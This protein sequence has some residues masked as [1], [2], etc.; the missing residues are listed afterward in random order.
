MKKST[1]KYFYQQ[2]I[3]FNR[4]MYIASGIV[5]V[6]FLFLLLFIEWSA[7]MYFFLFSG[8]FFTLYFSLAS[9]FFSYLIY[10]R[11]ELYKYTWLSSYI[12]NKESVI[13]NVYSGYTEAGH[14]LEN[15]F[16]E[17]K[18]YHLDFYDEKVSITNSIRIAKSIS[19]E[20]DYES[21]RFDTWKV[22]K[23]ASLILFMQ[24]LHELREVDQQVACL[25]EASGCLENEEGKMIVVEHMRDLSN[26]FIYS[27]GAFHFFARK[28]WVKVFDFAGTKVIQEFAIT[29]F[30]RVFV[31]QKQVN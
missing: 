12:S 5:I 25:Q 30:V 31:L 13:F 9:V 19:R 1:R 27:I 26:F 18:I 14:L 21:I 6:V 10:D 24:S 4:R 17:N 15:E 22:E 23:K 28:R 11:S 2:I 7:L 20:I 8:V 29:P 16:N 3:I